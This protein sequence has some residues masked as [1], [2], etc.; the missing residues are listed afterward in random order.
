MAKTK[1]AYGERGKS[2]IEWYK[3]DGAPQRYCYGW[4]D[5]MTSET[6]EVCQNC[7]DYISNAQKDLEDYNAWVADKYGIK[8]R[9]E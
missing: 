5:A 3:C 8:N 6:L 1:C 9:G 2:S 7:P 4:E